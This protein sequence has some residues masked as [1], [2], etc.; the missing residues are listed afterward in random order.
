[1]DGRG[2]H[3]RMDQASLVSYV[4][5][6]PA[7]LCLDTFSGHLTEEVKKAFQKCR[8]KLLLIPG[9]CTSILQPLDISIN[10]PFKGYIRQCWCRYMIEETEKGDS[11]IRRP[12]KESLVDWILNAQEKIESKK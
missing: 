11:P 2:P 9:G 12:P 1:M 6:K 8:T 7:L 5:G 3:A 10:K 4:Q